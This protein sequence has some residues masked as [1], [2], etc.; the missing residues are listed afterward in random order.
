MSEQENQT[1]LSNRRKEWCVGES[2]GMIAKD[3]SFVRLTPTP[4]PAT[5]PY[6]MEAE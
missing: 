6:E 4:E 1:S 5:D 2:C 3:G